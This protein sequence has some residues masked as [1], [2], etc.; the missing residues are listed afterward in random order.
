MMRQEIEHMPENYRP[1]SKFQNIGFCDPITV[2]NQ[3]H[4]TCYAHAAADIIRMT[5]SRI[6]GIKMPIHQQLIDEFIQKF[7]ID[8]GYPYKCIR[9]CNI[10]YIH[11]DYIDFER[12]KVAMR[13]RPFVFEYYFTDL[14]WDYLNP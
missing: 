4:G 1:L 6:I 5:Y 14:E 10:P 7:G 8:G 11:C 3:I 9:E 12:A 13:D 2:S